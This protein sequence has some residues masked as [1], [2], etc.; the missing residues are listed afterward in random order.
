[1]TKFYVR[2]REKEGTSRGKPLFGF[3]ASLMAEGSERQQNLFVY[4]PS[5]EYFKTE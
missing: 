4:E 3:C 5:M 2:D 1:M